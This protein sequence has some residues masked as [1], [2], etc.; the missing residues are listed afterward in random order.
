[1]W[2]F[3][4]TLLLK[5]LK[6]RNYKNKAYLGCL[7][8]ERNQINQFA[9]T[10]PKTNKYIEIQKIYQYI[11][12]YLKYIKHTYMFIQGFLYQWPA[13]LQVS[14]SVFWK[15][16]CKT[17]LLQE[18]SGIIFF[19][20]RWFLPTIRNSEEFWFIYRKKF[21]HQILTYFWTLFE[22]VIC[23][24]LQAFQYSHCISSSYAF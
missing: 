5:K 4:S 3:Q 7:K 18:S 8:Y 24:H 12:T 22:Q 6:Q 14:L 10:L 19:G 11:Y 23:I 16:G 9:S 13:L 20:K 17:A 1:M 15:Q 2:I 21:T